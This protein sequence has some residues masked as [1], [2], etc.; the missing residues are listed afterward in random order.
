MHLA[1]RLSGTGNRINSIRLEKRRAELQA[2]QL[3]KETNAKLEKSLRLKD[4]FLA[5]VSHE[6]RTPMNGIIGAADLLSISG[7]DASRHDH[8]S[9][10]FRA[11]HQMMSM[12]EKI[13]DFSEVE[14]S[15]FS[16]MQMP[17][18]LRDCFDTLAAQYLGKSHRKGLTFD[19]FFDDK[20]SNV[21]LGDSRL[22]QKVL[23]QLLANALKFTDSGL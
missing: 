5:S 14:A 6:L 21:Y 17:F 13:L 20:L 11:S 15:D 2:N 4:N 3:L 7:D 9:T 19:R 23:T 16:T 10:L 1:K 18:C 8:I 22:V 12:L